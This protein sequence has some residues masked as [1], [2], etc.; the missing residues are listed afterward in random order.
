[1]INDN[2]SRTGRVPNDL[3]FETPNNYNKNASISGDRCSSNPN[4][5]YDDVLEGSVSVD[6][7][8]NLINRNNDEEG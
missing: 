8:F 3:A 7:I 2:I 4:M 1:M 5:N 6:G